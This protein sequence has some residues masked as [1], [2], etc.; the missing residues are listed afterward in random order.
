MA[1][2]LEYSVGP[3]G[4]NKHSD[5]VKL[6]E[7]LNELS[8]DEGGPV[9]KLH[10]TGIF[11]HQTEIALQEFIWCDWSGPGDEGPEEGPNPFTPLARG[12]HSSV[13]IPA[14]ID[15]DEVEEFEFAFRK[16]QISLTSGKTIWVDDWH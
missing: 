10:V 4:V 13:K 2:V 11:T 7:F 1:K 14:G 3:G 16:I 5:V 8:P 15:L 6:Q 9:H 12:S